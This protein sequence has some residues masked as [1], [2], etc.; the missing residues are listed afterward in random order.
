MISKM[1][2]GKTGHVS[3][4]V[5]FGAAAFSGADQ[6]T[7][8]QTLRVLLQYGVNH[9][10]VA[11]SYGDAE[12]RVGPWMKDHR[13]DFFLATK[14]EERSREKAGAQIRRSLERL[15]TGHVD[16]LQLHAV[17]SMEE[18][19][20]PRGRMARWKPLSMRAPKAGRGLSGS[21]ATASKRR[22]SSCA[23]SSGLNFRRF[24]S[25]TTT[26]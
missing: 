18:L 1:P 13:A 16:L 17:T 21:P 6:P 11:A 22:R 24:C 2:F 10:D 9:I 25:R 8:D 4:R 12:L 20:R 19:E 5:L 23:R 14:T 26:P 3:S 7:A 15:R